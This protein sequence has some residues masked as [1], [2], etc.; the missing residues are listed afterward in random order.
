MSKKP[1][2]VGLLL[3]PQAGTVKNPWQVDVDVYLDDMTTEPPT[4]RIESY[5]QSGPGGPLVFHNNHRPGFDIHFHLHDPNGTGY[6]FPQHSNRR[7]AVWSRMGDAACPSQ[8]VCEVLDPRRV[9]PDRMTLVAHNPNRDELVGRFGYV[10][11]VV[12][13]GDWKRL[14]PIGDNQNGPLQ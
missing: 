8:E 9:E 14:D 11:R 7:A 3:R 2:D 10:L 12:K 1:S 4:F 6:R 13:D 5:L